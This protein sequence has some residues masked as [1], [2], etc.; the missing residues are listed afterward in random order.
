MKT[1]HQL[2][3]AQLHTFAAE[4]ILGSTSLLVPLTRN[5]LPLFTYKLSTTKHEKDRQKTT[6]LKSDCELFSRL[7]TAS[8]SSRSTDLDQFFC[9]ENQVCQDHHLR[10]RKSAATAAM[11]R[12]SRWRRRERHCCICVTRSPRPSFRSS[13]TA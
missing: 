2:G 11:R 5:K 12:R 4:R 1:A 3:Y 9:H 8:Q 7:Y 6:D 13:S 10:T